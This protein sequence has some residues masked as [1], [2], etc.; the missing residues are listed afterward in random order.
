LASDS[1]NWTSIRHP[2]ARSWGSS[3][4][5]AENNDAA[6]AI[7]YAVRSGLFRYQSVRCRWT[8]L[9][10][11]RKYW[12]ALGRRA[13]AYQFG[14]EKPIQWSPYGRTKCL[15]ASLIDSRSMVGVADNGCDYGGSMIARR[16]PLCGSCAEHA[17]D[18][19]NRPGQAHRVTMRSA[20]SGTDND[21]NVRDLSTSKRERFAGVGRRGQCG[22]APCRGSLCFIANVSGELSETRPADQHRSSGGPSVSMISWGPSCDVRIFPRRQFR[23]ERILGTPQLLRDHDVRQPGL[24]ASSRR[25]PDQA[26]LGEFGF[27]DSKT[28]TARWIVCEENI[29]VPLVTRSGTLIVW[30]AGT[31]TR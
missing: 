23:M 15:S 11:T 26:P 29:L 31:F 30:F 13:G 7:R 19:L 22:M 2:I 5:H 4:S 21:G 25:L 3:A 9:R 18:V 10:L 16:R 12:L 1:D 6:Q 20:L 17:E 27:L 14:K 24:D 8:C 28:P